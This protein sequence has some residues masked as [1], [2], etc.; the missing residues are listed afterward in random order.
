MSF[1]L[2]GGKNQEKELTLLSS[3]DVQIELTDLKHPVA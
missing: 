1:S 3:F 2:P